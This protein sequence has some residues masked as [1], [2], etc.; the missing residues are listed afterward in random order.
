VGTYD[1][2]TSMEKFKTSTG[3]LH[4]YASFHKLLQNSYTDNPR[5]YRIGFSSSTNIFELEN[6]CEIFKGKCTEY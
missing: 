4:S 2:A 1:P 6:G 3:N 5:K